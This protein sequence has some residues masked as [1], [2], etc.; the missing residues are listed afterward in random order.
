MI[1]TKKPRKRGS[2]LPGLEAI[3]NSFFHDHSNLLNN[4]RRNGS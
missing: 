3:T 1:Q 4:D 2:L